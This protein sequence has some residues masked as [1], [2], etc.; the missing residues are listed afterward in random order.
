MNDADYK[1]ERVITVERLLASLLVLV[2]I[3][4]AAKI[5]GLPLAMRAFFLFMV[6]LAMIWLPQLLARI[7]L[8]DDRWNRDF[9]PPP[10]ALALRIIAWLVILGVPGVWILFYR[11]GQG[12]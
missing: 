3:G 5:G 7:A 8:R 11:A 6:P 2:W 1:R 10:S 12:G 4:L 9:S